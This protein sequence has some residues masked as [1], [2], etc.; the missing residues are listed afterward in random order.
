MKIYNVSVQ[1][2]NKDINNPFK[3]NHQCVRSFMAESGKN[4]SWTTEEKAQFEYQKLIN[5]Y[6]NKDFRVVD[7]SDKSWTG[8]VTNIRR[9]GDAVVI[10]VNIVLSSVETS[11]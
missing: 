10:Y 7:D 9:D 11:D 2:I 4:S 8:L 1:E 5:E 6:I 3:T